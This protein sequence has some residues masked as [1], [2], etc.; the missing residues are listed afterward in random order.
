MPEF[1]DPVDVE[2]LVVSYLG[3]APAILE[4]LGSSPA[5]TDL[6]RGWAPDP[7]GA[8]GAL[9]VTRVGGAPTDPAGH[10]DPARIQIDSF[11][12]TPDLANLAARRSL[13]VLRELPGSAWRYPG[14]VVNDV[15]QGVGISRRD[16]P[17]TGIPG[18]FLE[19]VLVVHP[20]AV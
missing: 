11:A 5:W 10:L 17:T 15:R 19:V 18:Y 14:A 20:V 2:D 1:R 4:I 16:D 8:P 7:H 3:Q 6:P 13:T 12:E 9:R